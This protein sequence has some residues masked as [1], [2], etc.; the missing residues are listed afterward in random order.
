MFCL[1]FK[2]VLTFLLSREQKMTTYVDNRPLH[3]MFRRQAASTPDKIAVVEADGSQLTFGELDKLTDT[4]AIHLQ[5]LGVTSDRCVGIYMDK[6]IDY[7]AAYI[8]ILKAGGAYIP[9]DISYPE[10]LL[11]SIIQDCQPAAVVCTAEIADR[12]KGKSV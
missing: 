1:K 8:A 9:L 7:T 5:G 2:L 3:Q 10:G 6:C 11:S 12:I 4:L